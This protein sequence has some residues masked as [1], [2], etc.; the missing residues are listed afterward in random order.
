M[1]NLCGC[2]LLAPPILFEQELEDTLLLDEV[3]DDP[4]P[5]LLVQVYCALLNGI[6]DKEV[7]YV[8]SVWASS[9]F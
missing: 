5:S 8:I 1:V 2:S 4:T 7:T 9:L 3:K 6:V